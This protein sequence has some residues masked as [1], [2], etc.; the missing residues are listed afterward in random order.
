MLQFLRLYVLVPCSVLAWT[1]AAND[2]R[3]LFL[4][5]EITDE[6]AEEVFS[7]VNFT[8]VRLFNDGNRLG[9][10][11]HECGRLANEIIRLFMKNRA[12]AV[13]SGP[14][15]GRKR[16]VLSYVVFADE[17]FA[18]SR[19]ELLRNNMMNLHTVQYLF[20]ST[21]GDETTT[22]FAGDLWRE[23]FRDIAFL[24][25]NKSMVHGIIRVPAT[26]A[27]GIVTLRSVG[28][29]T[30]S[31]NDLDGILPYSSNFY[32]FCTTEPCTLRYGAVA[33]DTEQFWRQED[34]LQM[35]GD[36]EGHFL[37]CGIIN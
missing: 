16:R 6:V 12:I 18:V 19:R 15:I 32:R 23:G 29:C 37:R 4:R 35:T 10:M 25:L 27:E 31:E 3:K 5:D 21:T 7:C 33:G 14:F 28:Y 20:V 13:G 26:T 34:R 36:L 11:C 2:Y 8:A 1:N 30:P 24:T 17:R 9:V 22:A